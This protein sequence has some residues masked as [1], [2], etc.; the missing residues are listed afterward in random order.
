M[1]AARTVPGTPTRT[2]RCIRFCSEAS[3]YLEEVNTVDSVALFKLV[4]SKDLPF[5]RE[6]MRQNLR[7][8]FVF[9][10]RTGASF[11]W[12]VIGQNFMSR[13]ASTRKLGS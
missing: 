12:T 13:G 7:E 3:V 5:G 1:G 2:K 4:G 11:Q 6:S 9:Q 8:G 10:E